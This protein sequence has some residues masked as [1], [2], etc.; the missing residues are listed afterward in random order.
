MPILSVVLITL[1]A[2]TVIGPV[3]S[4][5]PV[6]VPVYFP[7]V[8]TIVLLLDVV[9][10]RLD[11]LA[12]VAVNVPATALA[13][14]APRSRAPRRPGRNERDEQRGNRTSTCACSSS[15]RPRMCTDLGRGSCGV[16]KGD[17]KPT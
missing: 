3:R 17:V 8:T 1:R 10:V 11:V 9:H 14:F 13:F 5:S 12:P 2:R 6:A 15:S 16:R 7:S 4:E